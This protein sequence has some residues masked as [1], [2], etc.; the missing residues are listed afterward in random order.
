MPTARQNPLRAK[1]MTDRTVERK[2]LAHAFRTFTQAA[3]SLEKS[4]A[5]LQSEVGRLRGELASANAELS[6]SVEENSRV[7]RSWAASSKVSPAAWW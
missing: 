3:G 1:R 6:R 5:Q 7:A 4:Y 2:S